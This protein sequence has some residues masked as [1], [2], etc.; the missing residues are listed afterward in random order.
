MS[1]KT[2]VRIAMVMV[3]VFGLI[4]IAYPRLYSPS[5]TTPAEAPPAPS[6]ITNG[7]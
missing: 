4:V 7:Q 5:G 1:H 3:I 2:L 6:P